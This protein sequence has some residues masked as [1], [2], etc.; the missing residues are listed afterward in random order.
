MRSYL[1]TAL[2]RRLDASLHLRDSS[3]ASKVLVSLDDLQRV[4]DT[5]DLSTGPDGPTNG[6]FWERRRMDQ[7]L[8]STN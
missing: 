4:Y 5:D 7:G 8:R 2:R 3:T 6:G 1:L